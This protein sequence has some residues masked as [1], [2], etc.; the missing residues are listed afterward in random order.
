MSYDEIRMQSPFDATLPDGTNVQLVPSVIPVFDGSPLVHFREVWTVRDAEDLTG[1]DANWRAPL[2]V[3]FTPSLALEEAWI[4]TLI[5]RRAHFSGGVGLPSVPRFLVI[6]IERVS[7]SRFFERAVESR[8]FGKR[9]EARDGFEL[10]CAEFLAAHGYDGEIHL[11]D[12]KARHRLAS[13][14]PLG[15]ARGAV[16][17]VVADWVLGRRGDWTDSELDDAA[18]FVDATAGVGDDGVGSLVAVPKGIQSAIDAVVEWAHG[19]RQDEVSWQRLCAY[20][21]QESLGLNDPSAHMIQAFPPTALPTLTYLRHLVDDSTIREHFG[22]PRRARVSD[23]QRMRY[24]VEVSL[25]GDARDEDERWKGIFPLD[26][27]ASDG[28]SAVVPRSMMGA[29]MSAEYEHEWYPPCRDWVEVKDHLEV[30]GWIID[31][32]EW[33]LLSPAAQ[34]RYFRP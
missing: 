13:T 17:P 5:R 34:R 15:I 28:R 32:E 2:A 33:L 21:E 27:R 3:D 10:F 23:T 7:G 25:G 6:Q 26:V 12:R 11:I 29:M 8:A 1:T 18:S 31:I 4:E 20:V 14:L 9:S 19:G 24:F 22:K 30:E 16:D